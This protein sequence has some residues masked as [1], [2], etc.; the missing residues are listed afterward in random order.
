MYNYC[1]LPPTISRGL[2][3]SQTPVKNGRL[4]S[5]LSNTS[6]SVPETDGVKEKIMQIYQVVKEK[7]FRLQGGGIKPKTRQ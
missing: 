5:F 1:E 7:V 6:D 2:R 3:G 4:P